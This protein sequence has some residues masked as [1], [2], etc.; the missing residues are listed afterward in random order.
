MNNKDKFVETFGEDN[1]NNLVGMAKEANAVDIFVWLLEEFNER[2]HISTKDTVYVNEDILEDVPVKNRRGGSRKGRGYDLK[3]YMDAVSDFYLGNEPSIEFTL[4]DDL[5]SGKKTNTVDG[6]KSRWIVA[7]KSL[8]L[9]GLVLVHKY[10][11][12]TC[13]ECISLEKPN[14]NSSK[15]AG[16]HNIRHAVPC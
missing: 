13:N 10:Y 15:A 3:W 12:D 5:S 2:T 11:K 7:V 16:Y 4:K 8:G 6:F 14:F 9:E 1:Y